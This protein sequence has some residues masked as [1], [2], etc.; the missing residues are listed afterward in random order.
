M[1]FL[2]VSLSFPQQVWGNLGKAHALSDSSLI[3]ILNDINQYNLGFFTMGKRFTDTDKWKRE[4]FMELRPHPKLAWIYLLDQCDHCGIWPR[5]FRLMSEQLGFRV[6]HQT[7]V[8]WFGNKLVLFDEDKYFIPS[9]FR[10]QYSESKDG[11]KAKQSA[12]KIL[13]SLN[14][15]RDDGT[16]FETYEHLTNTSGTVPNCPSKSKIKIKIKEG[17]WGKQSSTLKPCTTNS[18][19]RLARPLA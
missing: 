17:V 9:F 7:L 12:V 2:L 13:L 8:D 14:L 15:I 4:W 5:N 1:Q 10:Y 3:S 16:L 18:P 19:A 6:D 11:F